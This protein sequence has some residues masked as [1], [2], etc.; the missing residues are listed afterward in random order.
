MPS[1]RLAVAS[2]PEEE[3]LA[4][5][6]APT[7][8]G[9]PEGGV[10][11]VTVI[12]AVPVTPPALAV[13]AVV[14]AATPVTRPVVDTVATA[15][16]P[17]AQAKVLADFGGDAVAVNWTVPPTTTVADD[18]VTVT[19]LT[20]GPPRASSGSVGATGFCWR[21]VH[22]STRAIATAATATDGIRLRIICREGGDE[23]VAAARVGARQL[24]APKFPP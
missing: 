4:M 7:S 3:Q 17:V 12:D 23:C 5:S 15:E 6:P 19:A 20:P 2:S 8:T 13:I 9:S 18:G 16:L 10:V 21:S 1:S 22:E 24:G 14:P 11:V